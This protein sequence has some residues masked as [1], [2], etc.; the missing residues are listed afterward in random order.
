MYDIIELNGKKV[1]ELREI[2]TTLEIN[3]VDKLK[4]Q[5]LVYAIL[6]EQALR[7]QPNNNSKKKPAKP[8]GKAKATSK[9]SD[10]SKERRPKKTRN[11]KSDNKSGESM[12]DRRDKRRRKAVTNIAQ[13]KRGILW[14]VIPGALIFKIVVIK[15][16]APS[17][18]EAPAKWSEKMAI[19]T[20]G[21]LCPVIEL[22][23][24]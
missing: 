18:D 23:G 22:K 4:K 8:K 12:R 24:G 19:S 1:A 6:D 15:L 14:I 10:D 17:I 7:P 11:E 3:R 21:L 2:A 5:D 20:A 16:T 9:D 13:T